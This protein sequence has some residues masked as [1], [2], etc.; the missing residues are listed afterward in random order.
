ML[1]NFQMVVR[2]RVIHGTAVIRS[3]PEPAVTKRGENAVIQPSIDRSVNPLAIGTILVTERTT[4]MLHLR[5]ILLKVRIHIRFDAGIFRDEARFQQ[6]RTDVEIVCPMHTGHPRPL[7]F[8]I[9]VTSK[10]HRAFHIV[11]E[12][13][14]INTERPEEAI[15]EVKRKRT[16]VAILGIV[17]LF[18]EQR[19]HR[20]K[21]P[22]FQI[23]VLDLQ[24][25]DTECRITHGQF[26]TVTENVAGFIDIL[27]AHTRIDAQVTIE[28]HHA[29]GSK[30]HVE[31][32]HIVRE[33]KLV[34]AQVVVVTRAPMHHVA[35]EVEASPVVVQGK[36]GSV[37]GVTRVFQS[38]IVLFLLDFQEF[39][40]ERPRI[41]RRMAF[42]IN[43]GIQN[44]IDGIRITA[45]VNAP[46]NSRPNRIAERFATTVIE[47]AHQ[48]HR[49]GHSRHIQ[50]LECGIAHR[51]LRRAGIAITRNSGTM[52]TIV[53]EQRLSL[54]VHEILAEGRVALRIGEELAA[55]A[56]RHTVQFKQH[57]RVFQKPQ[58]AHIFGTY[59]R[60]GGK[61]LDRGESHHQ[62]NKGQGC[63][64]HKNFQDKLSE[65]LAKHSEQF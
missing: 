54:G 63:F 17:A 29:Q 61:S 33:R 26:V 37:A 18:H 2:R 47:A 25:A 36:M 40:V 1:R 24:F 46:V 49:Q 3:L 43:A 44:E 20:Y 27:G 13:F 64:L 38:R 7:G 30:L 9:V 55:L 14:R 51:I 11:E 56:R 65:Y 60:R 41:L 28:R 34:Q 15:V 21:E 45:Q 42:V 31:R 12:I 23:V 48:R 32:K 6:V 58:V 4:E 35:A 19:N 16:V 52:F 59:H 8:D 5:R 10:A 53:I 62:G 57:R 22:R 50:V 39:P